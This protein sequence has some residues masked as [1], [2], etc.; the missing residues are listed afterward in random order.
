MPLLLMKQMRPN[1]IARGFAVF[2]VPERF[3]KD[4]T[5]PFVL[6]YRPTRWGGAKRIELKIPSCLDACPSTKK[7]S[8][9]A[10]KKER[11]SPA[12]KRAKKKF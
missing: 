3:R 9:G 6:A 11:H 12:A 4:G 5:D 8:E 10:E 7:I 1:Q 2:D